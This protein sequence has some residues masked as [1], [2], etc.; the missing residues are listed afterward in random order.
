M[1]AGA[2][3]P[4]VLR[5]AGGRCDRHARAVA[6]SLSARSAGA[7]GGHKALRNRKAAPSRAGAAAARSPWARACHWQ[8][9]CGARQV[10]GQQVQA[11][12]ERRSRCTRQCAR[13]QLAHNHDQQGWHWPTAAAG[14]TAR[15][16]VLVWLAGATRTRTRPRTHCQLRSDSSV[17][18]PTRRCGAAHS[19]VE[20]ARVTG[21]AFRRSSCLHGGARSAARR[22]RSRAVVRAHLPGARTRPASRRCAGCERC[23]APGCRAARGSVRVPSLTARCLCAA[24]GWRRARCSRRTRRGRARWRTC[25]KHSSRSSPRSSLPPPAAT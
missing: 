17:T 20:S 5:D 4:A 25:N 12:G 11:V 24:C 19:C 1:R 8:A 13:A 22:R 2:G 18:G 23:V 6:V 7:R 15:D 10:G 21:R 3:S 16:T 14:Q 9:E